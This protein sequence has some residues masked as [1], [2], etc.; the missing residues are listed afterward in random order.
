MKMTKKFNTLI[1]GSGCAGFCTA[2]RLHDL[3]VKEIAILTEGV[4]MGTSRNTGSDKQTYYKLSLCGEEGDSVRELGRVLYS[5]GKVNG[6]TA[7][8]EAS[9]SA[10][11]FFHLVELGVPFPKNDYGEYVGYKTDHDPRSRATSCGPLTSKLMTEALERGVKEREIPIFDHCQ[12]IRILT[13]EN[14]VRGVLALNE[15]NEPVEFVC[16]H[17]VLATGGPAGIYQRSVYPLSQTGALGLA[18]EAGADCA[19][20]NEWQYGLAS[21]EFRWNVSG[22]YQQCLP[23]YVSVDSEGREH[24]F[25]PDYFGNEEDAVNMTF[26]KGYQWPF[27]SRKIDGSS[28]VDL[29]VDAEIQKGNRVYMDFR[30]NPKG[31]GEDFSILS[32]E[33]GTYLKNSE[34]LFGTPLE[35]LCKMNQKAYDLYAAH[36]IYLDKQMLE[37]AVCAQHCNGGIAVDDHWQ[38]SV[39]GLYAAGEAAGTF[40]IS[41]PG[42]TALNSTQ[43]SGIRIAE[44]IA[45]KSR[46]NREEKV[47]YP[48]IKMQ[49][50]QT[51]ESNVEELYEEFSRRMSDC[52][53][54]SRNSTKMKEL[55]RDVQ[56]LRQN[57]FQTV[58]AAGTE[59]YKRFFKLY[60]LILSQSAVLSAMIF[61]ADFDSTHGSAIVDGK[62]FVFDQKQMDFIIL[63][64]KEGTCEQKIRP[65]PDPDLWFER[66]WNKCEKENR[67][68]CDEQ[69]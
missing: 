24:E 40:G 9:Y 55:Y 3:G 21:T 36:G 11:G 53:A 2:K 43:V 56:Q 16:D 41:R 12:V 20:L 34:A 59:E 26:L 58:R 28:R 7:L 32:Q 67:S 6:D 18:V 42:G 50:I 54:F 62:P 46:K 49:E 23:R 25:L 4:Q 8:L 60:D 30:Q 22:T 31:L 10:R 1:I 15:E 33:A 39:K 14:Q 13:E 45:K 27:D 64:Q 57:F 29:Y 61:S 51:G 17:V 35:R 5:G 44:H 68:V 63:T 48:E 66:V 65:F 69:N 47:E 19:N 52:A 37:V 38:S